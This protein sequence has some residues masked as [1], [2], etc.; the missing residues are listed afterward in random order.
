MM[1]MILYCAMAPTIENCV[2]SCDLVA[3]KRDVRYLINIYMEFVC[4]IY[5][6][7]TIYSNL[8][9]S[10]YQQSENRQQSE[11][12]GK[13]FDVLVFSIRLYIQLITNSSWSCEAIWNQAPR[14]SLVQLLVCC[15]FGA[16]QLCEPLM[17]YL[18]PCGQCLVKFESKTILFL[19]CKRHSKCRL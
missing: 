12:E 14:S 4:S 2:C 11:C 13:C 17:I 18:D 3:M 8:G 9:A 1:T 5:M 6:C 16:R 7:Y 19:S 10:D 15:L